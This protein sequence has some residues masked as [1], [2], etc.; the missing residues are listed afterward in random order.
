MRGNGGRPEAFREVDADVA[1][2]IGDG[3]DSTVYQTPEWLRFVAEC[4]GARPV[5]GELVHDGEVVGSVTALLVSKLGLRAFGSPLP[6]WTTAYMGFNVAPGFPRWRLLRA[7][8]EFAIDRLGCVHLE[9]VDPLLTP[10]DGVR[11]G[12]PHQQLHNTWES[13]LTVDEDELFAGMESS[14][15]RA[16]RKSE[17]SGVVVEEV[18]HSPEETR[19]F[20]AEYYEQLRQVFGR[21]GLVPTYPVERVERLL[22]HLAP[23]GHALLLRARDPD[24]TCIA[25]NITVGRSRRAQFWGGASIAAGLPLRPNNA[26]HWHA[27]RRWKERG[28]D[29]Y[30]W[31]G[32][33]DYKRRY[34]GRPVTTPRFVVSRYRGLGT[35]RTAAHQAVRVRQRMTAL[36]SRSAVAILTLGLQGPFKTALVELQRV[37]ASLQGELQVVATLGSPAA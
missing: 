5:R 1:P 28:A 30:D 31:G 4:Q 6:G 29:V 15:R 32:G 11:A 25:T 7:L 13:D 9:L 16:I 20:A 12:L 34:G 17:K 19:L 10:E 8:P 3:L 2:E 27:M 24:G 35:L 22:G 33:G 23:A 36:V 21:Q 18:G 14:C 37:A 26:L